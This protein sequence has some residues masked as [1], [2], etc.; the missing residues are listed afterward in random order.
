EELCAHPAPRETV[1]DDD[2]YAC[3]SEGRP[4][5]VDMDTGKAVWTAKEQGEPFTVVDGIA[6]YVVDEQDVKAVEVDS[7]T[8]LWSTSYESE[9]Y[10]QDDY[11]Y[12]DAFGSGDGM[13]F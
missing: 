1:V 3:D 4:Q 8:T 10:S 7:G 5:L 2:I 12:A 11:A 6:V 9:E 13:I